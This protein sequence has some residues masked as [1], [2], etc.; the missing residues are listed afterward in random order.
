L[1]PTGAFKG[2]KW[3]QQAVGGYNKA[4]NIYERFQDVSD[5]VGSINNILNGCGGLDDLRTLA[6]GSFN[7]LGHGGLGGDPRVSNILLP[8]EGRVGNYKDLLKAGTKGDNITPHHIPSDAHMKKHG[9]NKNDG[10]A[11]DMEHNYP[12]NT[13]RHPDTFTFGNKNKNGGGDVNM[14]SRDALA[15]GVRDARKIYQK[16][17]LYDDK[18]RSSLQELITQNKNAHPSVFK[19]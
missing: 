8:G 13:G 15:T 3:A 11:I 4:R 18:I 6:G 9:V 2:A 7:P 19:K 5:K 10:I 16:D 12:S 1:L 14:N 17:G